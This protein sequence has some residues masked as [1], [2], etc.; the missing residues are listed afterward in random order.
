[1]VKWYG[2]PH[3]HGRARNGNHGSLQLKKTHELLLLLLLHL[4]HG[5]KKKRRK[6]KKKKRWKKKKQG[7]LGEQQ[8]NHLSPG[9]RR[10][11]ATSC[12]NPWYIIIAA[13]EKAPPLFLDRETL[14]CLG[15]EG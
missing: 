14:K 15:A 1:M 7:F 13:E 3:Q 6:K 9:W 2:L 12:W 11:Q 5:Q 4:H 10:N 8:G